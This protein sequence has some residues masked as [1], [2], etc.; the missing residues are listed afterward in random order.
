MNGEE[1]GTMKENS[2][3]KKLS[4]IDKHIIRRVKKEPNPVP[5]RNRATSGKR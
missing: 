3:A 2:P 5:R 1:N 4:K